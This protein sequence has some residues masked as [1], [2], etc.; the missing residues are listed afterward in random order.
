[1][2]LGQRMS[3]PLSCITTLKEDDIE[4]FEGLFYRLIFERNVS[5]A[6]TSTSSSVSSS[7]I[8]G[9]ARVALVR[10][11]SFAALEILTKCLPWYKCS[12]AMDVTWV[13]GY[14]RYRGLVRHE[15]K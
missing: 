9:L 3:F 12:S 2:K 6:M 15:R 10:E 8:S 4:R 14:R 7:S 5:G 1:M 13:S 11:G